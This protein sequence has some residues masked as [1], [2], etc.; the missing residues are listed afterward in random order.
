MTF[1]SWSKTATNNATIDSTIN[2]QEGQ[3]PST[4]NDS[5]RAVMAALSKWRD[6]IGGA[7]TTTDSAGPGHHY[8]MF[9]NQGFTSMSQLIG[10]HIAFTLNSTNTQQQV[11]LQVDNLGYSIIRLAPGIEVGANVL[12]AGTPYVVT[13]AADGAFYLRGYYNIPS[14]VPV[15]GI[16]Q[17]GGINPPTSVWGLCNGQEVSRATYSALFGVVGNGNIWGTGN[18]STTFNLPDFRGRAIY[19]P[20]N[21]GG[22]ASANRLVSGSLAGVRHTVG[23][24]GGSDTVTL[25]T[26]QVP[27]LNVSTSVSVSG[28]LSGSMSGNTNA[29]NAPSGNSTSGGGGFIVSAALQSITV[30]VNVSGNVSGTLTGSGTGGTT[31][32]GGQAHDNMPP[33]ILVNSLIRLL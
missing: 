3:A 11:F 6:D 30:P 7:I 28:T 21:M 18:G 20:D 25:N 5:A 14:V 2:W 13:F 12:V 29:F 27:N 17:W 22:L 24:V 23:G 1:Y 15:G 32:G 9:S 33:A 31:N 19:G 26:N 4:I 8:S 16:I 10:K